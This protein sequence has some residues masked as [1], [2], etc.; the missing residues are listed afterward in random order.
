MSPKAPLHRLEFCNFKLDLLLNITLTINKNLPIDDILTQFEEILHKNLNIGKIIIYKYNKRWDCILHS[1]VHRDIIGGIRVET[2]LLYYKQITNLS[3]ALNSNLEIFDV[4]IPIY[5]DN[6]P[7]AYVLIGDIDEERVG[8]SPTIKHLYFIQTLANII[9]VAIENKRL[10]NESVEQESIKKELELASRMQTM[11]I[12]NPAKLPNNDKIRVAAYYLPHF[13]VGG[14]YY[15]FIR[16]NN[17][18]YGFCMADVSGKGISAALLMSNFQA[19]VRALFSA[20]LSL[21]EIVGE[22]NDRVME[23]A[24]GEKFI[25]LFVGKY[26]TVTRELEYINAG[27]NPSLFLSKEKNNRVTY[28]SE[29]CTGVGMLDTIPS[30]ESNKLT[31]NPGDKLICYTDG[32]VE[33]ENE[34]DVEFGTK[35]M[36]EFMKNNDNINIVLDKII[37]ELTIH[38]GRRD[39]FDDISIMGIEFY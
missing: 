36:E 16:L 8:I 2:D 26:N 33:L 27:H 23:N 9:I 19:N 29:G 5:H 39:F 12:P 4:V 30:I 17:S 3:V 21:K 7:I 22:L 25:T 37:D 11:L 38:K 24:N 14:D 18:E 6:I 15:D 32:V 31:I 28:L 13:D 1:G 35:A 10:F 20:S 34:R